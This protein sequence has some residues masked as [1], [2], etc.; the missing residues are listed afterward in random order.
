MGRGLPWGVARIKPSAATALLLLE[1]RTQAAAIVCNEKPFPD[2][3]NLSTVRVVQQIKE[4]RLARK[5]S[6]ARHLRDA[7]IRRGLSVAE[8]AETI[9][10]S[11]ATIYF[12]ESD[13]ARPR[14]TN[15]TALCKAL[16]LPGLPPEKWSSLR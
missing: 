6:F 14:D 5:L 16:R 8:L 4:R 11:Q 1:A 10:V 12:W 3:L 9:G 2:C 7:R 15:L 13:R